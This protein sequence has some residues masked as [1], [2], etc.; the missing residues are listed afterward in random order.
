MQ[1][2]EKKFDWLNKQLAG[3]QYL[4]GDQFTIADAYLFVVANWSNFV[5]I[6]LDRW[7]ALKE[8]QDRVAARP[9]VQEAMEAEGLLKKAA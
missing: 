4:T 8:F 3:K 1:N 7:P 9:K 2:L 5:G 6:D